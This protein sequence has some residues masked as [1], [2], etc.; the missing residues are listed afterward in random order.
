[1]YESGRGSITNHSTVWDIISLK[2]INSTKNFMDFPHFTFGFTENNLKIM[3]TLPDKTIKTKMCSLNDIQDSLANFV[4]KLR[5]FNVHSDLYAPK[6]KLNQRHYLH[7]RSE[8][9]VD[10]VLEFDLRTIT[11]SPQSE[12]DKV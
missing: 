3:F 7:R 1:D 12:N 6:I 5:L 8:P 11:T 10:G 4:E 9:I 2:N